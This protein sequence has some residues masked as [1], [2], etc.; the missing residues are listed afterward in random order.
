MTGNAGWGGKAPG[1]ASFKTSNQS[2]PTSASVYPFE[3]TL[4]A[5]GKYFLDL[6]Q[7]QLQGYVPQVQAAFIDN[8][9]STSSL[10]L[11]FG[12]TG[13]T[14]EIPPQSQAWLPLFVA[15][16]PTVTF[17]GAANATATVYFTNV[18]MPAAVW[19]VAAA[20][21]PAPSTPI[22]PASHTIAAGGTAQNIFAA[23]A[24]PN[25]A[26]IIN[27]S[28]ASETLYVD[29]VTAAVAGSG[30]SIPIPPGGAYRISRPI[31]TAVSVV[32]A[33]TGHTFVAV[34]Y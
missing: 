8:S 19:S 7:N 21:S 12:V 23:G 29:V 2:M 33:T 16:P 30:T 3:I 13:F 26:D 22:A 25:V 15:S 9:A 11:L 14:I 1:G 10:A 34:A 17:T 32:A 4:D 5:S 18:P 24:I 28:T 27:P 31:S 20:G 6:T